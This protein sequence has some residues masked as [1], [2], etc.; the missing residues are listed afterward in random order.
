MASS[1]LASLSTPLTNTLNAIGKIKITLYLMIAW[2]VLT[3]ILGP[4]LVFKIG[5]NGVAVASLLIGLTVVIPIWVTKRYVHFNLAPNILPASIASVFIAVFFYWTAPFVKTLTS[6]V[7]IMIAG[8]IIYGGII[9]LLKGKE[10]TSE[11]KSLR[12]KE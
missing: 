4:V 2:T 8:G 10:L 11:I 1:I 6:L 7:F 3:W 12:R 5:F 9:F